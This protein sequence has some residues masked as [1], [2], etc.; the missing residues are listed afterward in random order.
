MKMAWATVA[1]V[2]AAACLVLLRTRVTAPAGVEVSGPGGAPHESVPRDAAGRQDSAVDLAVRQVVS[3]RSAVRV[4]LHFE[5]G[6]PLAKARVVAA[7][8]TVDPRTARGCLQGEAASEEVSAVAMSDERGVATI[9]LGAL[10]SG[11]WRIWHDRAQFPQASGEWTGVEPVSIRLPGGLLPV[12][13]VVTAAFEGSDV[14]CRAAFSP[15]PVDALVL[16]SLEELPKLGAVSSPVGRDGRG[17]AFYVPR[18]GY[19]SVFAV[20]PHSGHAGSVINARFVAKDP[21]DSI[22]I[23]LVA[24]SAGTLELVGADALVGQS[25][26]V[27]VSSRQNFNRVF[28][29]EDFVLGKFLPD[30]PLGPATV[31][32]S[33]RFVAP[34]S[35]LATEAVVQVDVREGMQ[36]VQLVFEP[37]ARLRVICRDGAAPPVDMSHVRVGAKDEAESDRL[38]YFD[39]EGQRVEVRALPVPGVQTLFGPQLEPGG[40]KILFVGRLSKRVEKVVEVAAGSS[41]FV[42]VFY[43]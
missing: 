27:R 18:D 11:P 35:T 8:P 7:R 29:N 6:S 33:P 31:E 15:R 14:Q 17:A 10:R 38:V 26:A 32:L 1:V 19:V 9:E 5:D 13:W 36:P 24:P 34:C 41:G 43:P 16:R 3:L 23:V 39:S 40:H 25:F 37:R 4:T 20:L 42:D 28:H 22:R 2:V 21:D 30:I 12:E